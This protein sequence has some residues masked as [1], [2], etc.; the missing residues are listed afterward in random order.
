M[1]KIDGLTSKTESKSSIE[2]KP[3]LPIT[4]NKLND[5]PK[6]SIVNEIVSKFNELPKLS[7]RNIIV[8]KK[9]NIKTPELSN[10]LELSV[11]KLVKLDGM[12]MKGLNYL[13]IC[14]F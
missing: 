7:D 5:V 3:I 8:T 4:P 11:G 6:L 2:S 1:I 14:E 9:E 10:Q 13:L 12:S